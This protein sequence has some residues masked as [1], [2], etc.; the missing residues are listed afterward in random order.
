MIRR[1]RDRVRRA[2]F[3]EHRR[4]ERRLEYRRI[5]GDAFAARAREQ[6]GLLQ[7]QIERLGGV[8]QGRIVAERVDDLARQFAVAARVLGLEILLGQFGLHLFERLDLAFTHVA[9]ID[10]VITLG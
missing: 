4:R 2:A 8:G 7:R 1:Q 5:R 10:D 9:Q 6:R 3:D